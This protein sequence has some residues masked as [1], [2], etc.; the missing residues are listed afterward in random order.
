MRKKVI[1][2]AVG[3]LLAVMP[4]CS[5]GKKANLPIAVPTTSQ[6]QQ[7]NSETTIANPTTALPQQTTTGQTAVNSA[8]ASQVHA[9]TSVPG[10]APGAG[11][12]HRQS[13]QTD[14]SIKLGPASGPQVSVSPGA[15]VS[16]N[17]VNGTI[18]VFVSAGENILSFENPMQFSVQ[19]DSWRLENNDRASGSTCYFE[20]RVDPSAPRTG[21]VTVSNIRDQDGKVLVAGPL[22]FWITLVE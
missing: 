9:H 12:A 18:N 17:Y 1:L 6:H 7:A 11:T 22:N 5:I 20:I 3:C 10:K 19:P 16:C 2:L 21:E 13:T 4:C 15:T 14:I 8:P